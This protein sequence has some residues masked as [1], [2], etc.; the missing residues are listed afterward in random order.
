MIALAPIAWYYADGLPL[1]ATPVVLPTWFRTVAPTL[2][3]RQVLLVFPVPYE[4]L[5]SAMTWQ[6]VN[7]MNY[8]M[9]GGG[10]PGGIP[11]RAG[12]ER[13]GQTYIGRFSIS[14]GRQDATPPV[15]T[16]A[17]SGAR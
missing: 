7:G 3:G 5:Q 15:V 17:A 14:K 9:V 10:G 8:S 4:L 11:P 1:T 6:A 13:V 12:K 16:A 2:K